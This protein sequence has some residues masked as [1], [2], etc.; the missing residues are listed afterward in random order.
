M[1][2]VVFRCVTIIVVR[3]TVR[4]LLMDSGSD[5][6]TS[7]VSISEKVSSQAARSCCR[8]KQASR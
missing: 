2:F 3:P 1:D 5:G 7:S 4:K 8:R 6:I